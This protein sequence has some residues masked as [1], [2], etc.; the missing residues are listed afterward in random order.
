MG[1]T[2]AKK[3]APREIP[4]FHS[5][6]VHFRPLSLVVPLQ[7]MVVPALFPMAILVLSGMCGKGRNVITDFGC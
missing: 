3:L 2:C 5:I 1:I 6:S 4:V 7:V